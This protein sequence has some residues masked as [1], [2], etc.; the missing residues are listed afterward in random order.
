MFVAG[1][2]PG[3]KVVAVRTGRHRSFDEARAV[4]IVEAAR[5]QGAGDGRDAADH[6]EHEVRVV[7]GQEVEHNLRFARIMA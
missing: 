4:E 3:E 5:E 1:A 7:L 6:G 2:L